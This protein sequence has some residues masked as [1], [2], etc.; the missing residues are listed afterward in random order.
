[1]RHRSILNG[2]LP[3]QYRNINL[4]NK[5]LN[6]FMFIIDRSFFKLLKLFSVQASYNF[7]SI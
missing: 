4:L 5:R 2:H 7:T 3:Q 1:M 6:K